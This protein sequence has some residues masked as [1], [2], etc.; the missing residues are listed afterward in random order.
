M[1]HSQTPSASKSTRKRAKKFRLTADKCFDEVID[2]CVE[3]HGENWLYPPMRAAF[4]ALHHWGQ[5]RDAMRFSTTAVA[6]P[7]ND[8]D[9]VDGE[10]MAVSTKLDPLPAGFPALL[11]EVRFHSF[12]V[13]AADGTLAAGEFGAVV[14]GV[15]TSFTGF[16]DP[17]FSGAG[18][19]FF[20]QP[21]TFAA[22]TASYCASD[23]RCTWTYLRAFIL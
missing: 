20:D 7:T 5:S 23:H 11:E 12:E 9:G 21:L 16:F 17:K 18:V 8:A 19:Y 15:Y 14:G 2:R 22:T 6:G 1:A 3:Q 10:H 13:W 4:R